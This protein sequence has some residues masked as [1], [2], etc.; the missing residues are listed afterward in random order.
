MPGTR[1]SAAIVGSAVFARPVEGCY[2]VKKCKTVLRV[3]I[4]L[5]R[6]VEQAMMEV[7]GKQINW[8]AVRGLATQR[9]SRSTVIES[10][11]HVKPRKKARRIRAFY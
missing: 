3:M 9:F 5:N 7:E 4:G 2:Q 11:G 6:T 10:P 8:K 1:R